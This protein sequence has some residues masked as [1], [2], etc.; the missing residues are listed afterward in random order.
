M[1]RAERFIGLI[2]MKCTASKSSERSVDLIL[3]AVHFNLFYLGLFR[4]KNDLIIVEMYLLCVKRTR[5]V[6]EL[7]MYLFNLIKESFYLTVM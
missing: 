7:W 1:R 6:W 4:N 3:F 5:T 2:L